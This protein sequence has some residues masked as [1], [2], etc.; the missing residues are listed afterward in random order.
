MKLKR[1]PTL[2]VTVVSV[3]LLAA[4]CGSSESSSEVAS[5]NGRILTGG[6]LDRLLPSGDATVPSRIAEIVESWL[7]TQAIDFEIHTRGA[8]ITDQDLAD[9][10][11]FFETVASDSRTDDKAT[12][13]HTYALSLAVGRWVESEAEQW[14]DPV[15]PVIL[16]SNH[17]LLETEEDAI[18]ALE[19]FEAGEDFANLAIELSTGP[20]GPGGGD[21][22]CVAQGQFVAEYEEAAYEAAGGDVIGPVQTE[23]GYHVIQIESLGPASIDIHPNADPLELQSIAEQNNQTVLGIIILELE[24]DAKAAYAD[25]VGVDASIGTFN[26]DDFVITPPAR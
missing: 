24:N 3:A 20:S 19:R 1:I 12:L 14:P 13:T 16:C 15:L 18:A 10:E 26:V 2:L 9:A 5:I 23:F 4:A 7:L 11:D 22:G 21:L 8:P 17:I 6:D 25:T